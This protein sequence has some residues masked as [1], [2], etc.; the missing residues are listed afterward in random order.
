MLGTLDVNNICFHQKLVVLV[1][2]GL[3]FLQVRSCNDF[4]YLIISSAVRLETILASIC[5]V[6]IQP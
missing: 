4:L 1:I 2:I 3:V 5:W 6:L